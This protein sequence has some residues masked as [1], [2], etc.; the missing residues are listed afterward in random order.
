MLG[1]VAQSILDWDTQGLTSRGRKRSKADLE[2]QF[3][4]FRRLLLAS[5]GAPEFQ[6]E[7]NAI[8]DRAV[9]FTNAILEALDVLSENDSL[10]PSWKGSIVENFVSSL[11][12]H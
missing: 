4:L 10:C 8:L 5:K 1:E 6:S 2:S 11:R 9:H 7:T 12:Q 3:Q